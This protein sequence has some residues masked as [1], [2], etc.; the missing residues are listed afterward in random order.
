MPWRYEIDAT[1]RLVWTTLYGVLTS[2]DC[3]R[4]RKRCAGWA[5]AAADRLPLHARVGRAERGA[6]AR[7]RAAGRSSIARASR[8]QWSTKTTFPALSITSAGIVA[9]GGRGPR[10]LGFG[11][12]TDP[13]Y[14]KVWPVAF[15]ATIVTA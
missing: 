13:V 12:A 10:R 15:F 11:I 9:A 1:K 6:A 14:V 8:A 3:T 7:S 4:T 2:R 5:S